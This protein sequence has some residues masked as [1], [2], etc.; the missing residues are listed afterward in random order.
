MGLPKITFIRKQGIGAVDQGDDSISG[1]VSYNDTLPAGFATN[2]RIK[3][4]F[5]VDQAESLGIVDTFDD[6]T[7]A[8]GGNIEVTTAG[9]ADD[10]ET[11]TIDGVTLGS[12]TIVSADAAADV[13]AGLRAAVNALTASHGF[14]AAGSL[15][16]VALTAPTGKGIVLNTATLAYA[17]TGT[18]AATATQFSSGV[19]SDLAVLHYHISEYFRQKSDG[20]L[21]VGIFE[22]GTFDA[23]ELVDMQDF[24]SGEIKQF[25]IFVDDTAF[26]SSQ[27][28]SIQSQL[29]ILRT[30]KQPAIAVF[31]ADMDGLTL[32]TLPDLSTLTASK[33]AV[34]LGEDGN[35]HQLTYVATKAYL[36]G[37]KAKWLDKTYICTLDN[38]GQSPYDSDYWT[39]VSVN[40]PSITGYSVS[41]L[42]NLLGTIASAPVN[43]S[44]AYVEAYPLN[45]GNILDI[46]GF[47]TGD[48]LKGQAV[49]LLNTLN[50][51]HYIFLRK[52]QGLSGTYYNDSYTAITTANDYATI[53]NNR[54]MNK[55]ERGQYSALLP[56]LNSPLV[57]NV[58]GTLSLDVVDLFQNLAD[59]P[60]EVME[61][62]NEVSAREVT[63]DPNQDVLTTSKI[64]IVSKIV[65]VGVA[66]EIEVNNSFTVSIS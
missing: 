45:S 40:L 63:V 35:F 18:G 41:T 16:N 14:V 10:V 64:V 58:D 55:V 38:T 37:D 23:T 8:T 56:K 12:Y 5:S 65:P 33:V 60:V 3:K 39:E 32:S 26:A 48:L 17:S 27:L 36:Q 13:A 59:A 61:I 31:H 19:G 11:I 66:R 34:A 4:I 54:T 44:I 51:Y 52:F 30:N 24:A 49:S 15:A 28:S 1:L 22:E 43:E 46:G 25:G 53:E 6:E 2:D 47:A 9:A 62:V 50:D 21:Y 57:L 20:V 42:G 29:E 7:A